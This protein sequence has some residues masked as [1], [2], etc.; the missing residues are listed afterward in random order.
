MYVPLELN[1][2]YI[3]ESMNS[4]LLLC[5]SHLLAAETREWL[6]GVCVPGLFFK[7]ANLSTTKDLEFNIINDTNSN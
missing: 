2:Q 3:R 4:K 6:K 5:P 7:Y 1:S